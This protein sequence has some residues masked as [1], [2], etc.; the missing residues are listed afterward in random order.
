[1]IGHVVNVGWCFR[2]GN[3]E[4]VD[5]LSWSNATDFQAAQEKIWTVDGTD[6]GSVRSAGRLSFVKIE[7]AV[8]HHGTLP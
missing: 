7:K 1:M 5:A 2:I 6:A 3:E 4:W 8:S